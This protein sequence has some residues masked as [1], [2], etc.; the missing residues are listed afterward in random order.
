MARYTENAAYFFDSKAFAETVAKLKAR[1][2][3]VASKLADAINFTAEEVVRASI[4][5]WNAHFAIRDPGYIGRHLKVARRATASKL[6]ASVWARARAT[7][8]DNFN[9]SVVPRRKGVYLNIVRGRSGGIL[10]RAFVIPR[11]KSNG[12]P[13]IV[14]RLQDYRP[15]EPRDFR[16]HG[17]EISRNFNRYRK[18]KNLRFKAVYAPSVNQHFYDSRDRVAPKALSEAKKQF[19]KAINA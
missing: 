7:R 5:E 11:A 18:A 6:E 15:G 16:H 14:E 10:N 3:V 12:K 4:A 13:L 9:Y 8:A 19:L 1:E 17:E 2:S